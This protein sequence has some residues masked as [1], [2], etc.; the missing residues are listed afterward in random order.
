MPNEMNFEAIDLAEVRELSSRVKECIEEF[1]E[2]KNEFGRINE[3]LL[4]D[5]KGFGA[6][7]YE[8]DTSNILEKIG[9]LAVSMKTL[10]DFYDAII[11]SYSEVDETLAEMNR[12]LT[13]GKPV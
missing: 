2:I 3:E 11:K 12:K 10:G 8:F 6:D 9:N 13:E 7:A 4:K 5:W 1:D